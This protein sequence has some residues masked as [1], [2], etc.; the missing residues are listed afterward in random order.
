MNADSKA[1]GLYARAREKRA[2][3][4]FEECKTIA[5]N[6]T[7][8]EKRVTKTTGDKVTVEVTEVDMLEHR[9]LQVETRKW[10]LAKLDPTRFGDQVRIE[11]SGAVTLTAAMVRERLAQDPDV[12]AVL[13]GRRAIEVESKA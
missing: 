3:Y 10:V 4:I 2:D 8:G 5:D 6:V 11:H 12:A 13:Q 1:A 7:K 9:R